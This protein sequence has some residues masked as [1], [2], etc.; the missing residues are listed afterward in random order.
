[1]WKGGPII[2]LEGSPD[3]QTLEVYPSGFDRYIYISGDVPK[4]SLLLGFSGY[5]SIYRTSIV[6]WKEKPWTGFGLKSFRIKLCLYLLSK[7]YFLAKKLCENKILNFFS[8]IIFKL[9]FSN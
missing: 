8:F 6:M 1:M 9:I 2:V 3:K 7:L 5:N 4:R